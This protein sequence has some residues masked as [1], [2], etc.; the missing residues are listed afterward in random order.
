M[1]LKTL[2]EEVETNEEIIVLNKLIVETVKSLVE[3]EYELK[4]DENVTA[5]ANL[6]KGDDEK[7][8]INALSKLSLEKDVGGKYSTS[9][10]SAGTSLMACM[11]NIKSTLSGSAK[12]C[13]VTVNDP[14]VKKS[15]AEFITSKIKDQSFDKEMMNILNSWKLNKIP[16]IKD[17]INLLATKFNGLLAV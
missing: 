7:T 6:V 13:D 17:A 16:N 9:L 4:L 11:D 12:K 14:E 2:V 10:Q 5:C 15:F 1:D 8:L 3:K